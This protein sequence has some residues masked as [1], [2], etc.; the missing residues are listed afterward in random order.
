MPKK[1]KA[2]AMKNGGESSKSSSKITNKTAFVLG[3]PADMSAKD[4]IDKGKAAG[5]TLTDRYVYS[6]RSKAKVRGSMVPARRGRPPKNAMASLAG[7]PGLKSGRSGAS[8][9]QFVDIAL[10]L[11]LSRAESLLSALRTR[12]R[13]AIA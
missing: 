1:K 2:A 4:V 3:F 9:A 13:Q 12:V 5:I 7:K 8:E 6:I 10:D 11:G